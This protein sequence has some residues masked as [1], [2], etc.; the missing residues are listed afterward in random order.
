MPHSPLSCNNFYRKAGNG[1]CGSRTRGLAPSAWATTTGQ[2]C[3]RVRPSRITTNAEGLPPPWRRLKQLPGVR[4]PRLC[5]DQGGSR[6]LH[7]PRLEKHLKSG[8]GHPGGI[9]GTVEF[10]PDP[11]RVKP[12]GTLPVSPIHTPMPMFWSVGPGGSNFF[13]YLFWSISGPLAITVEQSPSRVSKHTHEAKWSFLLCCGPSH[14]RAV[15]SLFLRGFSATQTMRG[16]TC[17]I[18]LGGFRRRFH[19]GMPLRPPQN[20]EKKKVHS[21]VREWTS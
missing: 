16:C 20:R 10:L 11:A 18:S 13:C 3:S 2:A 12:E 1:V 8:G 19:G 9:G 5:P 21:F 17:T 7:R 15:F 14:T 4:P 6:T